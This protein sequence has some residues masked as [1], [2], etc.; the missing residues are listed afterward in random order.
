MRDDTASTRMPQR[1][2]RGADAL[3]P[4]GVGEWRP[5]VWWTTAHVRKP[6]RTNGFSTNMFRQYDL[7]QTFSVW[8]DGG[9]LHL[10]SVS[11]CGRSRYH[12]LT[13][14][15]RSA[16][17]SCGRSRSGTGRGRRARPRCVPVMYHVFRERALAGWRARARWS[18]RAPSSNN[19]GCGAVRWP[20]LQRP[21][22]WT[23]STTWRRGGA[24]GMAWPSM[25]PL[26]WA[27]VSWCC[28][29]PT[30]RPVMHHREPRG[31][32]T[33]TGCRPLHAVAVDAWGPARASAGHC[34]KPAEGSH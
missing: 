23:R 33:W 10:R 8:F 7:H 15:L 17:P 13:S 30:S 1:T 14:M 32:A 18:T 34:R 25:I 31:N 6:R 28:G 22:V 29:G 4:S 27:G 21:D 11:V 26:R 2:L 9:S 24:V 3:A 16:S 12:R 20:D 19:A 5:V